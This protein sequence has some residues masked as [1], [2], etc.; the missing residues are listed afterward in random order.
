M[1]DYSGIT[2]W[3]VDGMKYTPFIR[4]GIMNMSPPRKQFAFTQIVL[5]TCHLLLH[6]PTSILN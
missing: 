6:K 5:S 3:N 4:D 2:M 1:I